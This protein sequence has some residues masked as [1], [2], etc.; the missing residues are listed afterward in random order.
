MCLAV[1]S[2]AYT[3]RIVFLALCGYRNFANPMR[4]VRACTSIE[5]SA[6]RSPAWSLSAPLSGGVS[7]GTA[8]WAPRSV[9]GCRTLSVL[10]RSFFHLV[11]QSSS[12]LRPSRSSHCSIGCPIHFPTYCFRAV[13]GVLVACCLPLRVRSCVGIVAQ[14]S[15]ICL[16]RPVRSSRAWK[17]AILPFNQRSSGGTYACL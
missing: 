12:T 4:P 6:F 3:E 16:A 9:P 5:L 10:F 8:L 7:S 11:V 15:L 14:A 2:P 1:S 13:A 17:R